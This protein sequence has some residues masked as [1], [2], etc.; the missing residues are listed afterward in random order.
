MIRFF[1]HCV[2]RLRRY[3]SCVCDT[4]VEKEAQCNDIHFEKN[5]EPPSGAL[6]GGGGVQVSA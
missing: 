6:K 1:I 2:F 3:G 5:A 4:K